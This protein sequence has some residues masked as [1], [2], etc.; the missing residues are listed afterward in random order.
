MVQEITSFIGQERVKEMICKWTDRDSF[1]HFILIA[2]EEGSGRKTIATEIAKALKSKLAIVEDISVD[3]VRN[4]VEV[5]YQLTTKMLYLIPDADPMSIGAKNALLKFTE[6]PP[7]N[8][9]IVITLK[10]F[11]NTLPTILSRAQQIIVEPYTVQEL[12]KLTS[13]PKY[14]V[15]AKTPGMLQYF[16]AMGE[17]KVGDIVS[18]CR[19]VVDKIDKVPFANAFKSGVNLKLREKDEGFELTAF[20][21]GLEYVLDRYMRKGP[22][23]KMLIRLSCWYKLLPKYQSLLNRGGLNKRAI[24]DKLIMEARE[25]LI[26]RGA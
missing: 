18:F 23:L 5:A 2:G 4:L 12:A 17:E 8:A 10:S 11:N 13:N 1:P 3:G 19:I 22:S 9:Y 7:V 20:L 24:Y 16:E 15:I 26:S 21:A 14:A 6:E 25:M